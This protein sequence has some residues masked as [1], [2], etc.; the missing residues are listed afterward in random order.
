MS[1]TQSLVVAGNR[2]SARLWAL[3]VRRRIVTYDD[4]E[5]LAEITGGKPWDAFW[6]AFT[7]DFG[8]RFFYAPRNRKE[9]FVGTL[10]SIHPSEEILDE[11]NDAAARTFDLLGSGP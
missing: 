10:A 4:D 9:F 1:L 5:I 2:L 7:T 6:S 8:A 3:C 11:A